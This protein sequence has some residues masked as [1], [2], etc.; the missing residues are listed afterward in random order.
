MRSKAHEIKLV[1]TSFTVAPGSPESRASSNVGSHGRFHETA[2]FS[3]D[4]LDNEDPQTPS[5][6]TSE[7]PD[8]ASFN[9]VTSSRDA[10]APLTSTPAKMQHG[11]VKNTHKSVDMDIAQ[12]LCLHTNRSMSLRDFL[13]LAFG[14]SP[15][16]YNALSS[17]M[18]TWDIFKKKEFRE[19]MKLFKSAKKEID[20][21]EPF[22]KMG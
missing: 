19:L 11:S 6:H 12:D 20:M 17:E 10:S 4:D 18:A 2:D 15:E 16:E 3:N 8:D 14:I 21:Y 22:V 13:Q 7:G 9:E 1:L 5:H